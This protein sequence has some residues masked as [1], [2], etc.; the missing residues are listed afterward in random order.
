MGA[1]AVG[2]ADGPDAEHLP[3]DGVDQATVDA[4]GKLTAALEIVEEAR[5]R[6]YGFH[7]LT[8]NADNDLLEALDAL[9]E[10]GHGA[11]AQQM[12]EDLLGKNVVSRRWTF[13]VVEDYDDT[14]WEPFRAW[15][16]RVRDELLE[17]RRHVYEARL[18]E[19]RRT[20]GRPGHEARPADGE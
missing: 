2:P 15:E 5:G 18:K 1:G 11:L 3:P 13:Q 6:L 17:G 10:A 9:E 14:Y 19:E 16:R 4:V 7:R 8:G 12:R 20:H